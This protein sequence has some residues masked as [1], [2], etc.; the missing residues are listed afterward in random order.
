MQLV[1]GIPDVTWV[2]E[3]TLLLFAMVT[4]IITLY[5]Q[6]ASLEEHTLVLLWNLP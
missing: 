1:V 3:K 5:T 6:L 2:M 4:L